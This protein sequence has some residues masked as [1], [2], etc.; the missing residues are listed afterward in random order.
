MTAKTYHTW[1]NF[2]KF[3][4]YLESCENLVDLEEKKVLPT[5]DTY[6]FGRMLV[7]RIKKKLINH[8]NWFREG[9]QKTPMNL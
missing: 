9:F 4:N 2:E 1:T 3:Q 7:N 5:V 6:F 8:N